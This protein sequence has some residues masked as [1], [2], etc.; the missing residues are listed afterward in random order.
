MLRGGRRYEQGASRLWISCG[1]TAGL[2]LASG[3]SASP[4]G[5]APAP[6]VPLVFTPPSPALAAAGSAASS[7]A[8]SAGR[9][10]TDPPVTWASALSPPITEHML[11]DA[12]SDPGVFTVGVEEELMLVDARTLGLVPCAEA[13][14]Q[15]ADSPNPFR[16][17]LMAAMVEVVT[18][19]M[20]GADDV[21]AVLSGA[22]DELVRL[23]P[24]GVL[25]AAA[26][27]HPTAGGDAVVTPSERY[28]AQD[29]EYRWASIGAGPLFGLHVH[30]AVPGPDRALAVYNALRSYLP[31]IAALA[32]N[33]PFH[34]G[35]DSGLCSIRPKL[36]EA[37]F[38]RAGTPPAFP[39]LSALVA[40][41]DWG[42][43]SGAFP[44]SS[45]LWWDLRLH[46]AYGTLEVRLPD[47]QTR[48]DDAA[49]VAAV[50]QATAAL[51]AARYD[52]GE[53]LP[54]HPTERIDENRWR[55]LRHGL[56]GW[57]AD[58]DTGE[59]EPTRRRLGALLD[60]LK[61]LGRD[62][63]SE[64]ALTHARTLLGGNGA[65][66]QRYVAQRSGLPGLLRWLAH[67]TA[68]QRHA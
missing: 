67:E 20:A 58:L 27:T 65:E 13:L 63:G 15:Q 60:E 47:A 8:G 39:S 64:D 31:E 35:R 10:G 22:R 21:C 14:L 4:L 66:R 61:D 11:R 45:H 2:T 53:Q 24:D 50:V 34:A 18:P 29:H 38:A 12:F 41:L 36:F 3:L 32:A 43:R 1:T 6:E 26:G 40:H 62:L 52:A 51:L 19:V 23:A 5:S 59:P 48:P 7:P 37:A 56:R 44:D 30:V 57:L 42:R 46:P 49:A 68:P 54:V 17:E 9:F 16:A 25:V 55:A 28:V 33:A